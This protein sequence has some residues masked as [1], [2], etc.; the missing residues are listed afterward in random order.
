MDSQVPEGRPEPNACRY[1]ALKSQQ[2]SIRT[3]T[4]CE[5]TLFESKKSS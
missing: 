5:I 4:R 1:A 3:Q 2:R